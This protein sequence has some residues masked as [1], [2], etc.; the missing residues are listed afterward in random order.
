MRNTISNSPLYWSLSSALPWKPNLTLACL[1]QLLP[2]LTTPRSQPIW[3]QNKEMEQFIRITAEEAISQYSTWNGPV[4]RHSY[5]RSRFDP[6]IPIQETLNV[7]QIHA[8]RWCKIVWVALDI[9]QNSLLVSLLQTFADDCVNW[10][11]GR[12]LYTQHKIAARIGYTLHSRSGI[13][14][15]GTLAEQFSW[16]TDA[17]Y[18]ISEGS[19]SRALETFTYHWFYPPSVLCRACLLPLYAVEESSLAYLKSSQQLCNSERW[20]WHT[21]SVRKFRHSERNL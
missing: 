16:T 14:I 20:Y 15:N 4:S 6:H 21:R 12:V 17:S 19:C 9:R 7:L 13:R 1:N 18:K 10:R 5:Q 11:T 8:R 3:K 2:F